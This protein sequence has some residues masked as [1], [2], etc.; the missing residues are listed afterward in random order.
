[1]FIKIDF[2]N[3]YCIHALNM[4]QAAVSSPAADLGATAVSGAAAGS[5][6]AADLGAAAGLGATAVSSPAADL[7][8]A[9]GVGATA[10]SGAAAGSSPAAI[11]VECGTHVTSFDRPGDEELRQ[12]VDQH[13]R[14]NLGDV[15]ATNVISCTIIVTP[16]G[17]QDGCAAVNITCRFVRTVGDRPDTAIVVIIKGCTV[18]Q[19]GTQYDNVYIYSNVN[20]LYALGLD[21]LLQILTGYPATVVYASAEQVK[22]ALA[23]PVYLAGLIIIAEKFKNAHSTVC[24]LIKRWNLFNLG[25]C[26]LLIIKQDALQMVLRLYQLGGVGVMPVDGQK[27]VTD[28]KSD[29]TDNE[30]DVLSDSDTEAPEAKST[31]FQFPGGSCPE[32]IRLL[33]WAEKLLEEKLPESACTLCAHISRLQAKLFSATEKQDHTTARVCMQLLCMYFDKQMGVA[34]YTE[35][36]KQIDRACCCR[37][38]EED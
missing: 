22:A 7:G 32:L 28:G 21:D 30:W 23:D 11:T 10:V 29:S 35:F 13:V 31:T 4:A 15:D 26:P 9:A 37:P 24:K 16:G 27:N 17:C 6:P 2:V 18:T 3:I 25:D 34:P 14:E 33:I 36:I 8:A 38:L 19:Y 20:I 12:R 1:M 5:S